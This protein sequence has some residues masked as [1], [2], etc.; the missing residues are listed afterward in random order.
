MKHLRILNCPFIAMV[1]IVTGFCLTPAAAAQ[2]QVIHSFRLDGT[3]G[4]FPN[5]DLLADTAGNLYGTTVDGGSQRAGTVFQLSP[6][7]GGGWTE[8]ILY[9]FQGGADGSDPSSGLIADSAGNLYGETGGGGS[10]FFG[11]VYKLTRSGSNWIKSTLFSFLDATT[12]FGPSGGLAFDSQGDLYG[13]TSQGGVPFGLG[14]VFQLTSDGHG[15]WSEHV[16]LGF[17]AHRDGGGPVSGVT[18]DPHGNLFVVTPI[19]YAQ[20]VISKLAPQPSGK[21]KES[22][23]HRFGGT[24]DGAF[25]GGGLILDAAGNLYGTAHSGGSGGNGTIY[26][27]APRAKGWKFSVLYAF[28]GGQDGA[29][30]NGTLAFDFSGNLLGT[31]TQGGGNGCDFGNGCGTIFKLSPTAKGPWQETVLHQFQA[32]GKDG[33]NPQGALVSSQGKWYG[34]TFTGGASQSGAVFEITP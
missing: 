20:G 25:P 34:T 23:L 9:S 18:L 12:G 15:N 11:T 22:V 19:G 32:D 6:K 33:L 3:D 29:G 10:N 30:P 14:T 26:K 13:T 1:M 7:A 16:I 17:G 24:K 5:R 8:Q 27:L 28:T 31:T 21:W 4:T 2:E